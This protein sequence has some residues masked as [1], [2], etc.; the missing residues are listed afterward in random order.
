MPKT[1]DKPIKV[2]IY[3]PRLLV[4]RLDRMAE[5]LAAE[6]PA[7]VSRNGLLAWVAERWLD[8]EEKRRGLTEP[9]P[10]PPAEKKPTGRPPKDAAP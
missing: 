8:K 9:P 3:F 2:S 6:N 10:M 7:T 4:A 1:P 5:I